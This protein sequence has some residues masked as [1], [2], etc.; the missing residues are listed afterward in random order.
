MP[1]AKRITRPRRVAVRKVVTR[2]TYARKAYA[3]R[4]TRGRGKYTIPHPRT[5]VPRGSFSKMGGLLGSAGGA[6]IGN[7][8]APGVGGAIGREIGNKVGELGGSLLSRIAGFGAYQ[9]KMN[10]LVFPKRPGAIVPSFGEDAIRVMK[11]E[12]IGAIDGTTAFTNTVF[13]I[14]PG[15]QN[16]FPWLSNI[17]RNY[18][19][20]RFNGLIFE[21]VSTSSDAIASTTNLGLGQVMLATDYNA[22]DSP[23]SDASQ[24]LN[25]MFSNS[26]KPSENI[27]HAIECAPTDQAQ[28]LYYVRVGSQAADTDIRLYDVGNFQLAT[29][30]QQS[31]YLGMGQLWV[32]YDITFCKSVEFNELGQ[33]ILTA[34]YQLMN[35][36]IAN[37]MGTTRVADIHNNLAVV[38]DNHSITFPEDIAGGFYWFSWGV[39]GGGDPILIPTIT[40]TNCVEVPFANLNVSG[41][42]NSG[43]TSEIFMVNKVYKITGPSA[44]ISWATTGALLPSAP[45]G[46]DLILTQ[47]NANV[48][49]NL[50]SGFNIPAKEGEVEQL[51]KQL[52]FLM[53]EFTKMKDNLIE[54]PEDEKKTLETPNVHKRHLRTSRL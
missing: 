23:Y 45:V 25:A 24:M 44:V 10:S 36:T 19:Q 53:S 32:S 5:F 48:F 12:Y 34:K 38:V 4:F 43:D 33:D 54:A 30:N 18:E 35:Q 51:R 39:Y 52:A 41:Q 17:A 8:V 50:T 2:R 49:G 1:R 42:T 46:G 14:N 37:T 21:F 15:Q 16:T 7:M 40:L 26:G 20:Y 31:N 6:A 13:A 11:R 9:V 27:I 3:P 22:A 47:L 28:K 29:Q